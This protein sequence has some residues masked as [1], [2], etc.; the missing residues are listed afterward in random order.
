M[1]LIIM[2]DLSDLNMITISTC[3][4]ARVCACAHTGDLLA[5]LKCLG[6]DNRAIPKCNGLTTAPDPSNLNMT[7]ISICSG[8]RVEAC[9]RVH[10]YTRGLF[11]NFKRAFEKNYFFYILN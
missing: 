10:T 6:A 3:S 2:P 7:T 9:E 4:G 11:L 8:A 1:G 5:R